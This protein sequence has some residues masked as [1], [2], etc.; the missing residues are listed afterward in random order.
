MDWIHSKFSSKRPW[1]CIMLLMVVVVLIATICWEFVMCQL[2]YMFKYFVY[3]VL[4]LLN[5]R[6]MKLTNV[7]SL[8]TMFQTLCTVLVHSSEQNTVGSYF[9]AALLKSTIIIPILQIR[10][11]RFNLSIYLRSNDW[12]FPKAPRKRWM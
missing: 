11:R 1:L 2:L 9:Y 3:H 7:Y 5:H 8:L 10:N 12:H 6:F 4:I